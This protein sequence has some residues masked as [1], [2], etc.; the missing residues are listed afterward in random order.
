MKTYEVLEKALG[1]IEDERNWC[2][3]TLQRG[4]A[5]CSGGALLQVTNGKCS[6]Q[7][8]GEGAAALRALSGLTPDHDVVGFNNT[9]SHAEVVELFQTAIREEKRKAGINL[10][11]APADGGVLDT[12][13][14]DQARGIEEAAHVKRD[15]APHP[16]SR[17]KASV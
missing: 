5:F 1:L 6:G 17:P 14:P 8:T 3:Y 15:A 7:W 13:G 12:Q 9:H 10:H 2:Q 16:I 4:S 11:P